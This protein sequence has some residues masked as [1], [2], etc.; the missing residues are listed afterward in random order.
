MTNFCGYYLVWRRSHNVVLLSEWVSVTIEYKQPLRPRRSLPSLTRYSSF[1]VLVCFSTSSGVQRLVTISLNLLGY[2]FSELARDYTVSRCYQFFSF[3]SSKEE[4]KHLT[5]ISGQS[6]LCRNVL[7][8]V[9][10]GSWKLRLKIFSLKREYVT[11]WI[12]EL[13]PVDPKIYFLQFLPWHYK[14]L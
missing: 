3:R 6:L 11:F 8:G 14:R 10:G 5:V 4:D 9:I 13:C 12:S 1:F 2:S 7:K